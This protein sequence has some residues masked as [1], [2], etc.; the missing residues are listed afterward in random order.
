MLYVERL[1]LAV[2]VSFFSRM[3]Q[4]SQ[5]LCVEF[6]HRF[7]RF[8]RCCAVIGICE[9]CGICEKYPCEVSAK[10]VESVRKAL[11]S[12]HENPCDPW[13]YPHAWKMKR[14]GADMACGDNPFFMT[15]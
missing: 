9:I 12:I 1:R 15:A 8:H 3:A 13:R 5:I 2:I 11:R 7:H 14:L 6:S 4:I 10:S